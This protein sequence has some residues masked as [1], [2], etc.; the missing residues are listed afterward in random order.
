MASSASPVLDPEQDPAAPQRDAGSAAEVQDRRLDA[1]EDRLARETVTHDA[2]TLS[3]FAFAAVALVASL[4]GV[5]LGLRALSNSNGHA[6]TRSAAGP[7]PAA[8]TAAHVAL[9]E[10]KVGLGAT[11]Q[12][13]SS[14]A[15]TITNTGKVPHELL[16]FRSDLDAAAY[17]VDGDGS[18][19][20]DGPGITKVSDGD[21]IDPGGTQQRSVDLSTPGKYVFV[22]NLPGH[23]KAGMFIQVAVG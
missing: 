10:F 6:A 21:N 4:I 9:S 12:A 13:A 19:T 8:A 17:P 16:V 14:H 3:I 1:L 20:E 2:W 23:F 22:C 18:I 5:G 11:S 15:Y 7:P